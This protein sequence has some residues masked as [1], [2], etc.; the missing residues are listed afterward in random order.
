MFCFIIFVSIFLYFTGHDP[1]LSRHHRFLC[2]Q[3]QGVVSLRKGECWRRMEA[4][5]PDTE[6]H[7]QWRDWIA[8]RSIRGVGNVTYRELL[9]RFDT[10]HAALS[11]PVAALIEAGVHPVVAQAI[12]AFDQWKAVDL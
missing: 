5:R 12:T 11:A 6:P 2:L 9:E 10:P 3:T 8:L 4:L 1:R 7:T